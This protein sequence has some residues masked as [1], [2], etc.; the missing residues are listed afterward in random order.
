VVENITWLTMP[1][2]VFVVLDWVKLII[3]L[4]SVGFTL[5]EVFGECTLK[6]LPITYPKVVKSV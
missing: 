5:T 4:R 2:T 6:T 3:N 1:T